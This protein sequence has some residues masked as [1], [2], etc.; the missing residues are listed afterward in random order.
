MN[1]KQISTTKGGGTSILSI[2]P[3]LNTT[4]T[5]YSNSGFAAI[6]ASFD[7][8]SFV[9]LVSIRTLQQINDE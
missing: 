7:T 4:T 2:N 6:W 8:T 1:T 5:V 3:F 9:L